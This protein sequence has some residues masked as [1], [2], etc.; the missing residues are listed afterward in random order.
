LD[1]QKELNRVN[2]LYVE[3]QE[4]TIAAEQPLFKEDGI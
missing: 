2:Q 1:V 4:I 3:K